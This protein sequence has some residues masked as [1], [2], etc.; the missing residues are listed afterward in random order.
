MEIR[1][2]ALLWTIVKRLANG[3]SF[4][5]TKSCGGLRMMSRAPKQ[6]RDPSPPSSHI[7]DLAAQAKAISAAADLSSSV[8]RLAL[9][10]RSAEV[11]GYGAVARTATRWAA[12][13]RR[14]EC[15]LPPR[16][17]KCI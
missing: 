3:Q 12:I 13:C 17:E 14:T 9:G 15:V 5:T 1:A 16:L 10:K 11:T 2:A 4:E 6:I 8:R 7:V